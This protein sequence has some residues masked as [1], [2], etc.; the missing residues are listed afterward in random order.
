M[1][2]VLEMES[3]LNELDTIDGVSVSVLTDEQIR[4]LIR[5]GNEELERRDKAKKEK[6]LEDAAREIAEARVRARQLMKEAGLR[7]RKV[8]RGAK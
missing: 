8:R 3:V 7:T 5:Q 6:A 2:E 1:P 4:Q